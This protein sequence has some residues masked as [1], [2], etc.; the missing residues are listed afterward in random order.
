MKLTIIPLLANSNVHGIQIGTE[1]CH[2]IYPIS[3]ICMLGLTNGFCASCCMMHWSKA[4]QDSRNENVGA[5]LMIF[6]ITI[7]LITGSMLSYFVVQIVI[8][9]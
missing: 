9:G 8:F 2:D 1:A 7:G 4:L 3:L 6:S 5:T